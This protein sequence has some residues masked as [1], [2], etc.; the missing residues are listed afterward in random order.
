MNRQ[1][2]IGREL[3]A[4]LAATGMS[5]IALAEKTGLAQATISAIIYRNSRISETS[6][7]AITHCW[8]DAHQEINLHLLIAHLQDEV[9]RA[10]HE[11][12]TIRISP[13]KKINCRPQPERDLETIA[14]HM[15]RDYISGIISRIALMLRELEATRN[16]SGNKQAWDVAAEEGTSYQ[17]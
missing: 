2:R 12:E 13:R 17:A 1:T 8:K 14:R 6:L 16:T 15:H 10:H 11:E 5:Q 9:E 3:S 4:A 7:K